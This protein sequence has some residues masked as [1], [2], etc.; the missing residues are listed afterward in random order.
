M[1]DC[2]AM[3]MI[4][5]LNEEHDITFKENAEF[6]KLNKS[7]KTSDKKLRKK[8]KH[9]NEHVIFALKK[10][11]ERYFKD[12][13]RTSNEVRKYKGDERALQRYSDELLQ[14]NN[15]LYTINLSL[16]DD[17]LRLTN[18]LNNNT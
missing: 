6:R 10:D 3:D 15:H 9:L 2:E 14:S 8:I 18:L 12:Y 7:L 17:V 5:K 13:L 4:D 16:K 1:D 11:K